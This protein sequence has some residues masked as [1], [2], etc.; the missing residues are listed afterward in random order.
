MLLAAPPPPA[1]PSFAELAQGDHDFAANLYKAALQPTGNLFLSP[2]SVRIALA[3][4]ASG[5]MGNTA[6]EMRSVL[7]L[8]ADPKQTNA[9]YAALLTDWNA[10]ATP[11]VGKDAPEYQRDRAEKNLITL[12]VV[13]RLWGQKGH[14]FHAAFLRALSE[15]YRAPLEQLDFAHSVVKSRERINAWVAEQTANKIVDLIPPGVLKPATKL[16]LTNAVYFKAEW[17]HS[18]NEGATRPADFVSGADKLSVPTM[19]LTETFKYGELDTAQVVEL[20][21]A[22]GS[23]SMVVVLPAAKDGLAALEQSLSGASFDRWTSALAAQQVHLALPKFKMGSSFA[24]SE[25]LQALGIK[26]A[27]HEGK[28]DLSGMDGSHKLFLSQ[29][30]QKTFIAVDEK[31]TEAAAATAVMVASRAMKLHNEPPP[32]EFKADHPF[33]FFLRDVKSGTIL[34]AGRVMNPA[35]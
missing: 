33:F 12:R 32:K 13:N 31:G 22:D 3:M 2:A 28:A 18:F 5:A 19:S 25:A 34:F 23:L 35:A 20:P 16:V 10:R 29:V 6:D 11:T 26:D 15:S 21:Y 30:V 1:P 17:T 14:K 9:D 24:L 4:T 27:F 7:G 8:P